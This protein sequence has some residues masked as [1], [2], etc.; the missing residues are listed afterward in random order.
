MSA[1]PYRIIDPVCGSLCD[2]FELEMEL[3]RY[4]DQHDERSVSATIREGHASSH[5]A[6][7][8]LNP[9]K[10]RLL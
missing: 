7:K 4:P 6:S 9:A 1:S 5:V 2:I 8:S 10:L 3:P